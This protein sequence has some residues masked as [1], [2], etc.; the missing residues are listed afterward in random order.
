[1]P[2]AVCF[3]GFWFLAAFFRPCVCNYDVIEED[4]DIVSCVKIQAQMDV[5]T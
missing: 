3:F 5:N 1:M 2:V 4:C